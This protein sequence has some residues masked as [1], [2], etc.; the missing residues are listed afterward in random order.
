[1]KVTKTK[2]IEMSPT[3]KNMNKAYMNLD[4]SFIVM[5]DCDPNEVCI[6]Q[7]CR[8]TEKDNI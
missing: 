7:I 4:K 2:L 8:V 5:V 6:S 3:I 1:M